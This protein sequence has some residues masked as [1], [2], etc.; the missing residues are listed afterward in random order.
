[1]TRLE[2]IEKLC[3][4][5]QPFELNFT[6]IRGQRCKVFS[7]APETLRDLYEE[8]RSDLEYLVFEGE[9]MTFEEV[10]QHASALGSAMI[11]EFGVAKGDRV[12]IAMRNY[13]EWVV[14]FFAV[15]AIGAIAVSMNAHWSSRELFYGLAD[16]RPKLIFVDHERL[17]DLSADSS[18]LSGTEIIRV[19]AEENINI[20]SDEYTKIVSNHYGCD[21]PFVNINADDDATLI[22]TSGSTGRPKGVVSTN[23][24]IIS[25]LLS[26][27]LDA[28]LRSFLGQYEQ[29]K[30]SYQE[31]FLL[32][33][34]LFHVSGSHVGM[35]ASLRSQRRL[36]LMY[37]WDAATGMDLI[38]RERVTVFTAAP[39]I[40]GDLIQAASQQNRDLSGL[41]IVGGG[42]AP[43]APAQVHEIGELAEHVVPSTGW[44]MTETNAIGTGI[45]GTT[46]LE[47]PSSSGQC[48]AVL[49]LRVVD[50]EGNILGPN[51]RGE[52]QVRGTSMF[53]CYWNRPEETV[54]AFDKDWF[55]TGDIAYMD[56]EGFLYIVDRAKDIVIRGGE[57]IACLAVEDALLAHTDVV[58]ACVYGLP[59]DRLGETVGATLLVK[60]KI[61]AEVLE[62][63]LGD[64]LA[65]FEIPS[66]VRQQ[67]APLPRGASGKILKRLLRLEA[68]KEL[69]SQAA[70]K[71]ERNS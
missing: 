58:E 9:R 47:R 57:N 60:R 14:A 50:A 20:R 33:V 38:E 6:Q 39:A 48:A 13:P 22:Y 45:L 40:T 55:K 67:T 12:A 61:D 7:H 1:M 5:G 35:L 8:T 34:P 71:S 3:A 43:R 54:M 37:K 62:R 24:S 63:F 31:S 19:R 68:S 4:P 29:P 64:R 51:S 2:A 25:A 36:I 66:L 16:C 59:D 44:G 41:L 28:E 23:R 32:S 46:Y 42:G 26:W 65:K 69:R 17:D 11:S 27:E 30:P 52:L 21:M 10:Y 18:L 15:T 70:G 56:R 53:R 49:E